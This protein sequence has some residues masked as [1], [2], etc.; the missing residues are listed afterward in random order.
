M[1][2][3]CSSLTTLGVYQDRVFIGGFDSNMWWPYWQ[4]EKENKDM[5]LALKFGPDTEGTFP[6]RG[7][8]D[9]LVG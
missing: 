3:E 8:L 4:D 6:W 1:R 7:D 9:P 5:M 2:T